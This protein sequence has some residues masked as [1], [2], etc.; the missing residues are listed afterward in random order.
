[1]AQ[2]PAASHDLSKLIEKIKDQRYAMLTT[3]DEQGHLH[4]RPMYTQEPDES[5][6]LWFFTDKES[7]KVHEVQRESQV[8]VAYGHPGKN[9]YVSVTGTA[10]VVLDRAKIDELW[11]E[12]LK[13]WFPKGKDDPSVALLRVDIE[14]GEYW[15]SPSNVLVQA[16]AY[17]KAVTTGEKS[18]GGPGSEHAK[19]ST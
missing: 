10:R 9:L 18:Q 5:G 8:G 4:A 15:D 14:R 7:A 16:Y 3:A 19:V 11:S 6:V 2:V 17:L 13:A 1:M 12:E